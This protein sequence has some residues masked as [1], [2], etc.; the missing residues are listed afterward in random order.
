M[1]GCANGRCYPPVQALDVRL[2]VR[3]D[4]RYIC[5]GL[6]LSG[7]WNGGG[8]Y[9]H[10]AE[11][12][13]SWRVLLCI[14]RLVCGACT[15]CSGNSL[16]TQLVECLLVRITLSEGWYHLRGVNF[17]NM[18]GTRNSRERHAKRGRACKRRVLEMFDAFAKYGVVERVF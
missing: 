6:P 10:V 14:C 3:L 1:Y 7:V 9:Y 8:Q 16:R 4:T 13:S 15:E 12:V 11:G 5:L 18:R 17:Q 2:A